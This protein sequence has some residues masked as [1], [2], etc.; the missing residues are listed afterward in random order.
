MI[1]GVTAVAL[2]EARAQGEVPFGTIAYAK[3][4][5]LWVTSA[6]GSGKARI[7]KNKGSDIC[8]PEVSPDGTK[9]LFQDYDKARNR[10]DLRMT[11]LQTAQSR[12]IAKPK[13]K[14]QGWAWSNDSTKIAFSAYA[15]KFRGAWVASAVS[16]GKAKVFS[17]DVASLT[18]SHDDMKLAFVNFK[19]NKGRLFYTDFDTNEVYRLPS[20]FSLDIYFPSWSP[21]DDTIA[22]LSYTSGEDGEY[23]SLHTVAADGT[24]FNTLTDEGESVSIYNWAPDGTRLAY[25]SCCLGPGVDL[26]TSVAP[27]GSDPLQLAEDNEAEGVASGIGF[28]GYSPDGTQIAYDV[29]DFNPSNFETLD[30]A[31]ITANADGSDATERLDDPRLSVISWSPDS[32][33]LL[34][35]TLDENFDEVLMYIQGQDLFEIFGGT[36]SADWGP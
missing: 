36:C 4:H 29:Y 34:L 25:S 7:Y 19:K 31:L 10:Y 27:D 6:D 5:S 33:A 35:C 22:F 2:P 15:K 14:V 9:V 17:G 18:W 13:F 32:T 20:D 24:G 30:Y 3:K 1:L 8:C 21:T 23:S 11:D 28:F 16:K 26:L 12:V